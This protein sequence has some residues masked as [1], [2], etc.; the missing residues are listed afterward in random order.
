MNA[1]LALAVGGAALIAIMAGCGTSEP[2]GSCPNTGAAA[3]V[4]LTGTGFSPNSV[5]INV[6]Q[7]VC[8]Q[9]ATDVGHDVTA[10]DGT[11]FAGLLTVDATFTHKFGVAG[12]F[13]YHCSVHPTET[14]LVTVEGQLPPGQPAPRSQPVRSP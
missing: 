5:T 11:S 1:R 14:G 12:F 2:N 13:P 3:T 10:D 8:W 9:N 6:D 4:T 7:S